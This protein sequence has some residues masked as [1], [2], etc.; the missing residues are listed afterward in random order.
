MNIEQLKDIKPSQTIQI[1]LVPY[2]LGVT[3]FVVLIVAIILFFTLRKKKKPTQRQRAI[4]HLKSMNFDTLEDKQIAYQFCQYGH[5]CL[6]DHYQDE[7][8]KIERQLEAFKYKKEVPI[9]DEDL[10]SQM[11]D[12][13]KVRL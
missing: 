11:K 8:F 4:V 7:F 13:I 12:Y 5:Q 2:F 6:E 9:I 1:D 10:K 3:A